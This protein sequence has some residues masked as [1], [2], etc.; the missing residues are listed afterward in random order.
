MESGKHK[1]EVRRTSRLKRER[2]LVNNEITA[3][4]ANNAKKPIKYK[5]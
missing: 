5:Y 1:E 2:D 3:N 4:N